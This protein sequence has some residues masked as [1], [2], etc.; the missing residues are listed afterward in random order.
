M[1]MYFYEIL[2]KIMDEK[3]MT[4]PDVARSSGLSDSTIRSIL[5]RK[6]KSAA[7][8]VSIKLSRGLGVDL[9]V[10]NGDNDSDASLS[11]LSSGFIHIHNGGVAKYDALTDENKKIIDTLVESL[12][13]QQNNAPVK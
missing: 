1:G 6:S 7:L 4:I 13:S 10:L 3:R 12:L 5:S 8:D 2:Q 11:E 9:M